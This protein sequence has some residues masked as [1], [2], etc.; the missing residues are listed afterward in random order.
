MYNEITIS[1][2]LSVGVF[3][4]QTLSLDDVDSDQTLLNAI[5]RK[6]SELSGRS[7]GGGVVRQRVDLK[8]ALLSKVRGVCGA[9]V[10]GE[11][12]EGK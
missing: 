11:H 10:R 6:L 2:Y 1:S 3:W 5:W 12:K 7:R 9:K 4:L 8:H